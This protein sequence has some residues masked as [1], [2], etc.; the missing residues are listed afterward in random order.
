MQQDRAAQLH[1][2]LTILARVSSAKVHT[3]HDVAQNGLTTPGHSWSKV[4]PNLELMTQASKL[5]PDGFRNARFNLN[6]TARKRLFRE[7][8]RFHGSLD[9]HAEVNDIG[10]KLRMSLGLDWFQPPII[11]NAIRVSACSMNAGIIV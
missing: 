7:P 11:P 8:C 1:N 9:V 4:A 6:I 2:G 3:A 5:L 10:H